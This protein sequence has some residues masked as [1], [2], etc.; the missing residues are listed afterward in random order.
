MLG[1]ALAEVVGVAWVYGVNSIIADL[2]IM[3][4][5]SE[6]ERG[7]VYVI[8]GHVQEAGLVLALLLGP[9]HPRGSGGHPLLLPGLIPACG[10]QQPPAP[11]GGTG[12]NF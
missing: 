10:L 8:I 4:D 12:D 9:G 7:I 5:R 11:P 2:N 1:L 3:L 6:G